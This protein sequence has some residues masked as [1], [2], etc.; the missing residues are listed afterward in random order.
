MVY[1]QTQ[2][3]VCSQ[4]VFCFQVMVEIGKR[5]QRD[6]D[7]E[8][9]QQKKRLGNN[10]GTRDSE[11]V[12]YRILCPLGVIGSVIGKSGKIINSIRQE[13]NAKIKIVDP[14]PGADKRVIT[15][16]CYVKDKN[17]VD[18]DED[19]LRPLCPAQDALLKIHDA[20]V[21][22]LDNS[23]EFENKQKE[24]V[25]ILVPASQAA[26]IIG[27]SGSIIKKLRSKTNANIKIT[28]KDPSDATH[29]CAMSFDNFLQVINTTSYGR[30]SSDL[31]MVL[32]SEKLQMITGDAEAIKRALTTVS[33][34]MY[35][36]SPKE[37]IPLD[38]SVPDLPPILFPSDVSI[39]PAGSLYPTADAILP[40]GSLPPV[41]AAT[42]QASEIPGF[43]DAS[44]MWPMYPSTLPVVPGYGGPARSEDLVL[45]VLCPFD[46]VGRVIGKQGNTIKSI[47]QSSGAKINIDDTRDDTDECTI[48]ITS[49]EVRI[50][51]FSWL[52]WLYLSIVSGEV[53]KLRDALVQIILR[54]R[55]DALKDKDG[56]QN[57]QKD[58]NHK[59]PPVDTLHSSSLSVPPVLPT[60]PSLAPLSY[61]QR[62][63]TESGM[64]IFSGNNLYGY[65]SL[66]AGENTFGP[67][68]SFSSN[69]YGGF[70]TYIEVVIPANA[71]AKVMGKGG[72]NV[73]NIRKVGFESFGHYGNC[74]ISGAHIEIVDSKASRFERI[75][76]ISGRALEYADYRYN[77][78]DV[79]VG[80]VG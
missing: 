16:Y 19:I 15:I 22:A 11:L 35:K 45:Q 79:L 32:S 50:H 39:I 10:D 72:T 28:P 34:I 47:R 62:A 52:L 71:L 57:S 58:S 60:I 46:K 40:P 21:N 41:I 64:G 63:E 75:A 42:H 73:D 33:A 4:T 6:N 78:V 61:G 29:S 67:L 13:T 20:I 24:G 77:S 48:T 69:T 5:H 68:S 9:K 53:G 80:S 14:F 17:P 37:E 26:N 44:N 74:A 2:D 76:R 59:V 66:Q 1:M 51:G 54:L 56:N 36:F 7:N 18:V 3:L 27:K 49:K 31:K 23:N 55:E 8:G 25:Y 43:I 70:P 38:S 65:N 12:V 30:L